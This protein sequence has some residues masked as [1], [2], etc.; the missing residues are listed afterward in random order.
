MLTTQIKK[1]SSLM[2]IEENDMKTQIQEAE[3][4]MKF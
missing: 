3:S 2:N 4:L 1:Q